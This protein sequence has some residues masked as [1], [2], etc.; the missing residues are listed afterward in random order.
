MTDPASK[1]DGSVF[2]LPRNRKS[3]KTPAIADS[4][5]LKTTAMKKPSMPTGQARKAAPAKPAP[6]DTPWKISGNLRLR[7]EDWNFFPTNAANGAYTFGA[8]QLRIAVSRTTKKEDYLFE[9]QETG[10]FGL[11]SQ[12]QAAA[13]IGQLGAGPTYFAAN[14]ANKSSIF[15]KQGYVKIKDFA[16]PGQSLKI[17]RF[18]FIDGL[19]T[20]ATDPT[21][22]W[23]KNNRIGHRL[24]GPF[25]FTHVGRS[26]DGIQYA[27]NSPK[28]AINVVGA[29]PTRGVFDEDGNDTLFGVKFLYASAVKPI[30]GKSPGEFRLFYIYYDDSRGVTPT[31][32]RP[33]A[34]RGADRNSIRL[35]NYGMHYIR[36]IPMGANKADVLLWGVGQLGK[37]GNLDQGSYAFAGE[38]GYQFTKLPWKPWIRAGYYLGSGDG[39]NAN[40]RHGTF[41]PLLPTVRIYA[42]YPFFNESNLEDTFVQAILKP[43]SKLTLRTDFR[44]LK[45]ADKNDLFY[46]GGGAY[47][48]STFGFSGRPSNGS[49]D[50]ARLVDISAD[51][52][53][54]KSTTATLYLAYANG[55]AVLNEFKS[56]DSV[57]AYGELNYKF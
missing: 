46:G 19:E 48:N 50:L 37:W 4:S 12:A 23:L 34:V 29:F 24:I 7:V 20:T 27:K 22:T 15:F 28:L 47:Q 32:N 40:G 10:L 38:L 6:T 16:T 14:G 54:N 18:E 13:P 42:R 44:L 25:S 3:N 52:A 41:V 9:L 26:F 2:N 36:T 17:G 53:F 49:A 51:Y 21:L 43:T 8:D 35:Q 55:G 57:Y 56:R 1:S 5:S 33:A 39:N 45:L 30:T 31:D 11:P